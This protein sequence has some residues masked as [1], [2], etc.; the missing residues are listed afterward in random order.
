MSSHEGHV[1]S[2]I[3]G[4]GASHYTREPLTRV[5]NVRFWPKASFRGLLINVDLLIVDGWLV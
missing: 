2:N 1:S 4:T 5:L 3:I